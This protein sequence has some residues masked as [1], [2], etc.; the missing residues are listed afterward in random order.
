MAPFLRGCRVK[1]VLR[2]FLWRPG[3]M[4]LTPEPLAPDH[5]RLLRPQEGNSHSTFL[6]WKPRKPRRRVVWVSAPLNAS[7]Q[8]AALPKF[9]FI[10]SSQE[11]HP[12]WTEG[13]GGLWKAGGRR[14]LGRTLSRI[15][16]NKWGSRAGAR[17]EGALLSLIPETGHLNRGLREFCTD[18]QHGQPASATELP[19]AA[20]PKG[21]SRRPCL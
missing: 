12:E 5:S 4:K 11:K 19:P 2:K 3:I 6:S 9:S 15:E 17:A 14:W 1:R 21:E 18:P 16:G 10:P 20:L 7:F 13:P 8:T